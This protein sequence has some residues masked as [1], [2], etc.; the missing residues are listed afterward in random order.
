MNFRWTIYGYFYA[1]LHHGQ[2]GM[3]P[4]K[5]LVEWA[6]HVFCKVCTVYRYFHE[7][8]RKGQPAIHK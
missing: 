5:L 4:C 2:P 6:L 3:N 1:Q 8:V 7:N